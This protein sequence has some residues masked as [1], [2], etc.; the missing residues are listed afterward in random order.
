VAAFDYK[1]AAFFLGPSA[2]AAPSGLEPE[3]TF[4]FSFEGGSVLDGVNVPRSRV[5]VQV[6]LEG[7][8]YSMI[9]DTGASSITVSQ[10]AFSALTADGRVQITGGSTE[11]TGGTSTSSL[12]RAASVAVGGV[13]VDSV[14][15][16]H[17][18]SFDTNLAAISTDVGK[19]IDGS[20]GGDFLHDFF[21][22]IDYPASTVHLARYSDLSW[23]ID[24]GEQIGIA[25]EASGSSYVIEGASPT[26]AGMGVSNGDVVDSID[27]VPLSGLSLAQETVLLYGPVGSTKSV[28]FGTAAQVENQTLTM[29]V[30]EFLP[31]K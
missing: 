4:P 18:T 15:V 10:A 25:L 9:L 28:H 14:V 2:P 6:S 19:T 22:T 7:T 26:V 13:T 23:A 5:V 24:Q 31:L 20:L 3:S 1:G 27:G 8:M 16:A 29:T 12:T 21:V 17:D 11:T 30:E